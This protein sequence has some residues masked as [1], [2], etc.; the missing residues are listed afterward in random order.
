MLP[1]VFHNDRSWINASDDDDE[2]DIKE[3]GTHIQSLETKKSSIPTL[4]TTPDTFNPPPD[5]FEAPLHTFG[6]HPY[7]IKTPPDIFKAPPDT[8]KAPPHTF[9]APLHTFKAPPDTFK[10]PPDTF[11]APPDE[12][13]TLQTIINSFQT[14]L[15]SFQTPLDS[16][17][18]PLDSLQTPLDSLQTPPDTF[19]TPPDMFQTPPDTFQTRPEK[20]TSQTPPNILNKHNTFHNH[21]TL[22]IIDTV[23]P[24]KAKQMQDIASLHNTFEFRKDIAVSPKD[25]FA[26]QKRRREKYANPVYDNVIQELKTTTLHDNVFKSP[27]F[28]MSFTNVTQSQKSE[29][30]T[31]PKTELTTYQQ[32]QPKTEPKRN[33]NTIKDE[34]DCDEGDYD[35][36]SHDVD[37]DDVDSDSDISLDNDEN[38][39]NIT[40]TDQELLLRVAMSSL[41]E[42]KRLP[43]AIN[44]L[45]EKKNTSLSIIDLFASSFDMEDQH[46]YRV[47]V[48]QCIENTHRDN[49][50]DVLNAMNILKHINFRADSMVMIPNSCKESFKSTSKIDKGKKSLLATRLVGVVIMILSFTISMYLY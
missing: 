35:V 1:V 34:G 26:K 47:Y 17:Q 48:R 13:N 36:A 21:N 16:L 18:T 49:I 40:S 9:K 42:I 25:V 24:K 32:P 5:T 7:I 27:I 6:A 45:Y 41:R 2:Q 31:E 8:F 28:E 11:K 19:Q 37:S 20:Q 39:S 50:K 4:Q 33:V 10:A 22:H 12:K 38:I 43:Q 46:K 3:Y 44:S 30:K 15:D 23:T 29:T 14:P